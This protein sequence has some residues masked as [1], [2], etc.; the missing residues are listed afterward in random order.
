MIRKSV[1]LE[2]E[3][4]KAELS[5]KEKTNSCKVKF[6]V[7]RKPNLTNCCSREKD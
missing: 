6:P 2:L 5:A 3:K 7:K 1:L 4:Q